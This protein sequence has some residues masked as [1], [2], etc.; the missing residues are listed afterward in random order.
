MSTP[1]S[2]T[3]L[4][5]APEPASEGKQM[6]CMLSVAMVILEEDYKGLG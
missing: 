6:N 4:T 1:I 3:G 2:S 5:K